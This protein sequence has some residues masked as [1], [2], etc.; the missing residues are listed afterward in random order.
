M[1]TYTPELFATDLDRTLVDANLVIGSLGRALLAENLD[2]RPMIHL[3][4]AYES[5]SQSYNAWSYVQKYGNSDI[6]EAVKARFLADCAENPIVYDDA[7]DYLNFLSE[8]FIDNLIMTNGDQTWQELKLTGSGLNKYPFL[9]IGE[10]TKGSVIDSWR[11]HNESFTIPDGI[12]CES[13]LTI[14]LVDDKISSFN[15]FPG[16]CIGY[17]LIRN[18]EAL[19]AQQDSDDL[20]LNIKIVQD[21][22]EITEDIDNRHEIL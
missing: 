17:L 9:I 3:V 19:K 10:E 4:D 16:D 22:L 13:T 8:R 21:L 5:L 11:D 7:Q 14:R 6:E 18:N 15:G 12:G 1:K 2:P 20:P